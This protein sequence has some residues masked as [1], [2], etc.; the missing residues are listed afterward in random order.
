MNIKMGNRSYR[1]DI[2]RPKIIHNV[3]ETNSSFQGK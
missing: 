3:F 1:Y 2:S